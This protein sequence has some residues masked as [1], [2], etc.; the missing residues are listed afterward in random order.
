[1]Y[2][3]KQKLYCKYG[4]VI[5]DVYW[6]LYMFSIYYGYVCAICIIVHVCLNFVTSMYMLE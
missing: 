5:A 1:M 2:E 4:F 6:L 3:C